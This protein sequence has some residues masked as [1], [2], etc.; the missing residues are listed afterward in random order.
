MLKIKKYYR[1]DSTSFWS[2]VDENVGEGKEGFWGYGETPIESYNVYVALVISYSETFPESRND[3]DIR[4]VLD[5][6]IGRGL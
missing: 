6:C 5:N 2:C 4:F 1:P 3:K